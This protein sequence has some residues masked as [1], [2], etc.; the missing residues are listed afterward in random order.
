M[1]FVYFFF[2]TEKFIYFLN[3]SEILIKGNYY[4]YAIKQ[5]L[6]SQIITDNHFLHHP[7][8]DSS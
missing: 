8:V 2:T 1:S 3:I 7:K 6:Q 4:V 5:S